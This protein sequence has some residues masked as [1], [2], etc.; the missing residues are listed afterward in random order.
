[1]FLF[2]SRVEWTS[3]VSFGGTD[4]AKGYVFVCSI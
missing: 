1:M 2:F 3:C 4:F